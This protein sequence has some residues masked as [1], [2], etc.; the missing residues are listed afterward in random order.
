MKTDMRK[1]ETHVMVDIETM[2]KSSNSVILSIGAVRFGLENG[3]IFKKFYTVVDI[4]SCLDLGLEVEGDTIEWWLRQDDDV[5]AAYVNSKQIH[6]THVLQYLTEFITKDDYV[7]GNSASFDLGILA[8]AFKKTGVVIPW[9][10][11]KEMC[12]RTVMN[13]A[14]SLSV[15][16]EFEGTRH[17][18]VNDCEHQIKK[19]VALNRLMNLSAF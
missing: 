1:N 10:Y 4:Q 9:D 2:G 17:D 7:W 15:N 6:V 13:L 5:R 11:K 18:P 19:L 14:G 3:E 8:N 12:Y 16:I